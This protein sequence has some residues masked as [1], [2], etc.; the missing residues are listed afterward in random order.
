MDKLLLNEFEARVL[1]SLIEKEITTPEYYPLSLN[2]LTNA[3][4]QINNRDPVVDYGEAQVARAVESLRDKR[5][6]TAI[7]GGDSRVVKYGHKA[8]DTLE[9]PRPEIAVLCVLLLRGPQTIGELRGRSAR[10]HE[11]AS[12]AEVQALLQSLA[13]RPLPLVTVLPRQAGTKEPRYAH[14]LAGEVVITPSTFEPPVAPPA[15]AGP[16]R[17]A[18]LETELTNLR[19]EL[20]EL[21]RQFT[22]FRK[23]LE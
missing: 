23:Q 13:A 9:L 1:G 2:A 4:N 6:A 12:L 16:D 3:C 22:E 18:Q 7:S 10:M 11:F 15:S 21:R 17:I 14:L 20:A 19:N 5:L 8:A